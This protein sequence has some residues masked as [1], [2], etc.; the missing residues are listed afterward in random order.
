MLRPVTQI[1]AGLAYQPGFVE[2]SV[3]SLAAAIE[4]FGKVQYPP[5]TVPRL[6]PQQFAPMEAALSELQG[7]DVAQRAFVNDVKNDARR[8]RYEEYVNAIVND[9]DANVF[10]RS[11]VDAA[12]WREHLLWAR[13]DIAHEGAPNSQTGHRYV[14]D[15]E[16]RAVRDASRIVLTLAMLKYLDIP[17][18]ALELAADRLGVRY[19]PRHIGTSIFGR[20]EASSLTRRGSSPRG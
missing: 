4:R 1:L 7:L 12:E 2:S 6:T 11:W 18:S 16:S 13:N 5:S 10:A 8:P 19:G 9:I 17:F 20:P 15:A 3:I 14:T